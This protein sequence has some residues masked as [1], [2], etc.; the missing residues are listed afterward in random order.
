MD[1]QNIFMA[2]ERI[3][4]N[5]ISLA[6]KI[7]IY[8]A[9]L[10]TLALI[11]GFISWLKRK[12]KSDINIKQN[13]NKSYYNKDSSHFSFG[14]TNNG[15]KS[16]SITNATCSLYSSFFSL[17][18][19]N[20][21][22]TYPSFTGTLPRLLSPGDTWIWEFNLSFDENCSKPSSVVVSKEKAIR[23]MI[24]NLYTS[25]KNKPFQQFIRISSSFSNDSKS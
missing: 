12:P 2:I 15:D 11:G 5:E 18:C 20:P 1:I 22:S 21:H 10:A 6:N 16:V 14:V 4:E 17:F 23:F 9:V 13:H 24:L 25:D 7:A 8:T 3:S 19:K